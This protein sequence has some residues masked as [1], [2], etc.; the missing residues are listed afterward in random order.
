M[1]IRKIIK[2]DGKEYSVR[3]D[4][5]R[6]FY[7]PE[8]IKFQNSFGKLT[9]NK[10]LAT[11]SERNYL[12]FRTLLFTGGRINE[13]T[14]IKFIDFDYDRNLLRLMVTKTKAKKGEKVGKPRTI[15]VPNKLIKEIKLYRNKTRKGLNDYVFMDKENPGEKEFDKLN[16]NIYQILRRRLRAIGID[17][18]EF[19]LHNI[20]KT[21]GNWL[22]AQ[23]VAAEEICTILGHDF[24]TYLSH[25][26]SPN[27]F[28]R[29][30]LIMIED[31]F[32]QEYFNAV[33]GERR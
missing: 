4:R 13:I 8:W 21:T 11:L 9:K 3:T 2:S 22:K 26:G 14:H 28:D 6:F 7:P 1:A 23:R 25:Y 32:G 30:D 20:R 29:T 18:K 33:R 15:R 31:I 17:E 5:S 27:V 16:K 12:L 19:G 24:D 10:K